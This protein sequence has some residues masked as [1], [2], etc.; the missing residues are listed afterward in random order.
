MAFGSELDIS[1]L[2]YVQERK[3]AAAARVR[4][5]AA[6]AFGP[7][8]RTRHRLGRVRPVVLAL[9]LGLREFQK[10]GRARLLEGAVEVSAGRFAPVTHA[11]AEA[12]RLLGLLPPRTFISPTVGVHDACVFGTGEEALVV[13]PAAL[14]D[15][16]SAAELTA[17]LGSALGRVHNQHT[18]LLT[19]LWVLETGAPAALRW[20]SRPARVV[21]GLWSQGANITADRAGL[22]VTRNLKA[23]AS[24]LAKRLGGGRRLLADI[25]VDEALAHLDS[26]QPHGECGLD[27]EAWDDWRRR[28]RALELFSQTAFYKGGGQEKLTEGRQDEG[29][30]P[31]GLTLAECNERVSA[32]LGGLL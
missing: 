16:L 29:E 1:F 31:A 10:T 9:E 28:V 19:S 30:P 24:A 15:H 14:V 18:P 23:T 25:R 20:V 27:F 21:L 32:L 26:P 22:L 11:L 17:T 7:E 4:E 12:S 13:L 5:G 6:Y 8:L 3:R 2:R